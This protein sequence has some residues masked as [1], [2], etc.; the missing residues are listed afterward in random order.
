MLLKGKVAL[1]VGTKDQIGSTTAKLMAQEGAKVVVGDRN[2]QRGETLVREIEA[3]GGE[4]IYQE[5]D[6]TLNKYQTALI[7][8]I[9]AEYGQ[10]DIAFNNVSVDG[11]YFPLAQ[12]DE[13]MVAGII[14]TNFN[15][16]WMSMKYQIQQMLKNGGGA[17]VNN[18][19]SLKADGSIGCS[20]YR[21]TKL[22]VA[23]MSQGAAVEYAPNNIRINAIS[24]G[25]LE[26]SNIS[27]QDTKADGDYRINAKDLLSNKITVPMGRNGQFQEIADIV[28][29]LCSDRASFI[30]GQVIHVDGGAQAL[31]SS[32]I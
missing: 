20:I 6:V 4:A 18:V 16:M 9:V 31:T 8:R 11:D 3:G 2:H 21:A 15:G 17:I 1:V 24:P 23:S 28:V 22:A 12:Q 29:W 19:C 7:E 30:T 26:K 5:I 13:G 27:F 14:D 25:I 32:L 10:L